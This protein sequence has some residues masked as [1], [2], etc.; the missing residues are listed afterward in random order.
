MSRRPVS[1]L[2]L[3]NAVSIEVC[4]RPEERAAELAEI[5]AGLSR[6]PPEIEP[7]YFYDER[8]SALF[9]RICEQPEYYQTRTEQA[10]LERIAD[11]VI[12]ATDA[13]ELVEL[14][15]GAALKTR[16]LLDAMQRAGRLAWYVPF[17]ISEVTVRRSARELVARYPGLRV[18]GV[19]G[20]FSR[21]LGKIPDEGRR[22]VM[23]LGGTIGNFRPA[24]AR[25]FLERVRA[26]MSP[27]DFLLLGTDRIKDA[28]RLVAAYN[29]AAGVTA[30]FNKNALRVLNRL[31]EGDFD[32]RA[33]VHR[34]P[35]DTRQARIEMW[36]VARKP[37]TVWLAELSLRLELAK[38]DAILTELS[39]K[40]D[41]AS[42][43][44]MLEDAGFEC[45][46]WYTDAEDLFGLTLARRA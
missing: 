24:E 17:D 4:L 45:V 21:H 28:K 26:E 40:F 13:R 15:S 34:A 33:F 9:E 14:G 46:A 8:G 12:A 38:D 10:L 41:R 30:Q 19:I 3:G 23:F 37:Q 6:R 27:G 18:H 1:S 39:Y 44:S 31:L 43:R 7:K 11:D 42:A 5:L 29:D 2:E 32:E 35:Y 20:D 22:L 25:A 16:V 36:L